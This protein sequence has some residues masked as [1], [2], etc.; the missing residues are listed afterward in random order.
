MGKKAGRSGVAKV[1][2]LEGGLGRAL[3]ITGSE[4]SNEHLLCLFLDFDGHG[5]LLS[6]RSVKSLLDLASLAACLFLTYQTWLWIFL[7]DMP[8]KMGCLARTARALQ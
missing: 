5:L 4:E 1:G 2:G 7:V 8:W 3:G 6:T